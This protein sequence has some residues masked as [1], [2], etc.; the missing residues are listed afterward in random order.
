MLNLT[1]Q[2]YIYLT[3]AQRHA[4][5]EGIQLVV[6][7]VSI[8][9]W[10][11]NRKTSEP[12]KEVFCKYYLKNSREEQPIR[13]MPDGYE[14]TLPYRKGQKLLNDKGRPLSDSE[15]RKLNATDSD[16]L[17]ELYQK[18]VGEISST[19]LL[20][21][22]IG[23]KYLAYREHNKITQDDDELMILHYVNIMDIEKL[24][25]TLI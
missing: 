13:I 8:P 2:H 19:L 3:Q 17:E 11:L 16:K 10:F 1:I 25:T 22:P 20:D 9:V 21:P 5:H 12:A 15:W 14:I 4:L 7:G 24:V 23:I 6:V 18:R